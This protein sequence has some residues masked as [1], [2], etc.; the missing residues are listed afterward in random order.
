MHHSSGDALKSCRNRSIYGKST[1]G[2]EVTRK[3]REEKKKSGRS[4]SRSHSSFSPG[5]LV[6]G[7]RALHVAVQQILHILHDSCTYCPMN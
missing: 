6:G 7:E 4:S 3:I 1:V 5:V 2:D